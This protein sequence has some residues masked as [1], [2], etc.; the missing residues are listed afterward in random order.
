[1]HASKSVATA[2]SRSCKQQKHA[3]LSEHGNVVSIH[4]HAHVRH[5]FAL[6]TPHP[7]SR[8]LHPFRLAVPSHECLFLHGRPWAAPWTLVP[9][10]LCTIR[11]VPF[12]LKLPVIVVTIHNQ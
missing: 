4:L 3:F 2:K 10:G 12:R 9:C 1:V 5:L 8:S 11:I 6:Q 7:R